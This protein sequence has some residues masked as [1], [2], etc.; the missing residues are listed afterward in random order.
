M[1]ADKY[2]FRMVRSESDQP[3]DAAERN[4]LLQRPI[5]RHGS[6][7]QRDAPRFVPGERLEIA[8]NTA[9]AV[10]EP[11]LITGEP[12]TGKTQAA[13]YA[14]YKLGLGE[15]LHFQVKSDS[16][17]NDLLYYFDS[18]R[19]FRDASLQAIKGRSLFNSEHDGVDGAVEPGRGEQIAEL[20]KEDYI[21]KRALWLAF[22]SALP[23]VL[24]IDEIDKAPRDFPNDL[25]HELDQMEFT[26]NETG[27]RIKPENDGARPIIF[28]T[29]N[30]E[31]RLPEP[32]L[33]RCVYH[34]IRF[35]QEI[36]AKAIK[37]RCAE[38]ATLN[39]EFLDMALQRFLALRERSLRKKPST[40][41]LLV[42][43]RVIALKVGAQP[44]RLDT[45]LTRLPFLGTLLKDHQDIEDLSTQSQN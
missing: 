19:Y 22:E 5:I 2:P 26:I 8:I 12:G 28:I 39:Q 13:Y 34:H 35:S 33:R 16:S 1:D 21:E 6:A 43:L 38:Y 11:L 42:W 25:L 31:R 45:D 29:S 20:H 41:E 14:A 44:E 7:L 30:S 10:G 18:V 37:S 9:I 15:V 36:V 23:K 24:L 4:L 27:K 32:F 17:A 3:L 40:G